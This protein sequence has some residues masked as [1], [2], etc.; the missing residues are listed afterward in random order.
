M[1]THPPDCGCDTYGCRL[2]RKGVVVSTAAMPSRR[3]NIPPRRPDPAWERGRA[4]ERRKD[5][6]F[7]P[8]LDGSG[9]PIGVKKFADNRANYETQ[10]K[11]LKSDPNVFA[12][13]RSA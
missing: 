5:G 4:G 8:Y 3:N 12:S 1:A 9:E 7:M 13:E 2:R 10:I 11:R 6:S